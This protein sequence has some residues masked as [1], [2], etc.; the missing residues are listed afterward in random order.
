VSEAYLMSARS[1]AR[2][3]R[4][5]RLVRPRTDVGMPIRFADG[6]RSRVFRETRLTGPVPDD[7]VI[8]VIR[9]RLAFL[10]D[11]AIL[12]AGFRRECLIHTPL[13]AGFPGF[14]SK[15]WLED[16]DTRIYRGLY[17][18]NGEASAWSYARCMVGLLQ[19]FSNGGTCD[20]HVVPG[21][22]RDEFLRNLPPAGTTTA[23]WQVASAGAE[24]IA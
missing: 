5:R 11:V 2:L 8:L 23:W 21:L 15:L 18:W 1:W 13:F 7:P 3:A 24:S 14:Y 4:D 10:D 16:R 22:R 17:E 20:F 12:H 9:F 19:P 6:T